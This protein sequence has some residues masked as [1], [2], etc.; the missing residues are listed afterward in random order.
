ALVALDHGTLD[1]D[2]V[3]GTE[4]EPHGFVLARR[5]HPS[6]ADEHAVAIDGDPA[7][8][9][10][11]VLALPE[12]RFEERGR[13]LDRRGAPG[14]IGCKPRELRKA[15]APSLA[16]T[17]TRPGILKVTWKSPTSATAC[18]SSAAWS[19]ASAGFFARG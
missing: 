4:A 19:R 10:R 2:L 6:T 8:E 1:L 7:G 15:L 5:R 13:I 11:R 3:V 14:Q 18:C 16:P 12:A 9:Q 17:L